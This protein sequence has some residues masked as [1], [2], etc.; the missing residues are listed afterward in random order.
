MIDAADA[1]AEFVAV[2]DENDFYR[3][4]LRQSAV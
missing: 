3:D 4:T 1:I 2:L